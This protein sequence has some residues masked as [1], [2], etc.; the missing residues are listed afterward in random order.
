MTIVSSVKW[1]FAMNKYAIILLAGVSLVVTGCGGGGGG[2]PAAGGDAGGGETKTSAPLVG[3]FID[4]AVANIHYLTATQSGV[5]NSNGEFNYLAGEMV[6]FSIGDINLPTTIAQPIIT[7]LDIAG[8]SD[9]TNTTAVNIA[10]LLQSLDTD[11]NPDNGIRLAEAAH[12]ASTGVTLDFSSVNFDDDTD[13]INLVSNGGGSGV[14]MNDSVAITHLQDQID[15]VSIAGGW[16]VQTSSGSNSDTVYTFTDDGYFMSAEYDLSDDVG[17]SGI[18][19]GTYT[20]NPFTAVFSSNVLNDTNGG[21]GLSNTT[22]SSASIS[23][24]TM[25]AT[26]SKEISFT[27]V[28]DANI[29]LAGSWLINVPGQ[30]SLQ[31]LSDYAGGPVMITFYAASQQSVDEVF[32]YYL[33]SHGGVADENGQP[34]MEFG[35]AFWNQATGILTASVI[36]DSNGQWGLSHPSDST[37]WTMLLTGNSLSLVSTAS[38]AAGDTFTKIE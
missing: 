21:W 25:T 3:V 38:S 36:N 5:T 4:S 31:T 10:Q 12:T 30:T 17:E 13:V 28:K 24:N 18:E 7:P 37:T 35:I 34:G 22:L 20:W 6:V 2:G 15:K 19:H 14:L 16:L 27:R 23:I 26:G 32:S 11:S 1:G 29:P 33:L 8:T 9:A